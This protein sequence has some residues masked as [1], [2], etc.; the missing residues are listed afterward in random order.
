MGAPSSIVGASSA[1]SWPVL[2]SPELEPLELPELEP[3]ASPELEPLEVPDEPP[4]LVE[5]PEL[6]DPPEL[7]E[8]PELPDPLDPPEPELV[9]MG[10]PMR[11]PTGPL[12]PHEAVAAM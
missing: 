12:L 7:V 9:S 3:L 5:P 1:A 8:P 10:P 11:L 4:E 6:A 2:A